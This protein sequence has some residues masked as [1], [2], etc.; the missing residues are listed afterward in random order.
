MFKCRYL[1]KEVMK[2]TLYL[3]LE[4]LKNLNNNTT[5]RHV[6]VGQ[7]KPKTKQMD[8]LDSTHTNTPHSLTHTQTLTQTL[9]Y[10]SN[11]VPSILLISC[12]LYVVFD[13]CSDWIHLSSILCL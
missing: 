9:T 10:H 8:F 13:S 3:K 1:F 6:I 2:K 4:L 11:L 12:P 5:S 7:G